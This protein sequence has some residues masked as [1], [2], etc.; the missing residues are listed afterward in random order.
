MN[1]SSPVLVV[2]GAGSGI[3]RATAIR[4]ADRAEQLVLVGR[5]QDRL[6]SVAAEV[7]AAG[8]D[9]APPPLVTPCDLADPVAVQAFS[10]MLG[11]RAVAGL[12]LA[13]GGV[14]PASDEPGLSGVAASWAAQL[15]ANLLTSV[16]I[17]EAVRDRL[18]SGAGIVAVGSI[19]GTRG[20]GS[21]GAAKAALVPWVR[22]L[23]RTL[24]PQNISANVI[25]PGYVAETEFFGE[26][27]T[28]ERHERLVTETFDGRPAAPADV[29]GLAAYLLSAEGRHLTGQVLHLNG[30]ALLAG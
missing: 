9:D 24:G 1:D 6:E 4:L 3:G 15:R 13:A 12:V 21:Y 20:G 26:A 22:D 7:R 28:A 25:A 10:D 11:T 16:L 29:A 30:G 19:A 23:A 17:T 14:A 5:R 18:A 2:T 8:H 27:M